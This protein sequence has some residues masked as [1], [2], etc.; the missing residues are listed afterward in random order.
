M[1]RSPKSISARP[2]SDLSTDLRRNG[3]ADSGPAGVALSLPRREAVHPT[4]ECEYPI[5]T[6]G[7][8][9]RFSRDSSWRSLLRR[10]R[11]KLAL[12]GVDLRVQPGEIFGLLGP[13]GAGK[14]TLMKVLAGLLLPTAGKAFVG[15]LDVVEQSLGARRQIG[16]VHGDER[17]FYWRLSVYEN[18]RFYARL[19]RIPKEDGER[20]IREL[21]DLVDLTSVA[22]VR[23]DRFSSGMKQRAAI[24]RGLLNDPQILLMDEPTRNLDPVAAQDVRRFINERVAADGRRTVLLATNLMAEAEAL[25]DRLALLNEGRIC[26]AGTIDDF[27]RA[28]Q[29]EEMHVIAVSGIEREKLLALSAIP[30]IRSLTVSASEDE[31]YKVCLGTARGS[32]AVPQAIRHIVAD[33]GYVWSSKP[34]ELSLEEV[35]HL[36][37]RGDGAR[38][39]GAGKGATS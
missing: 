12:D 6:R 9:K 13:N 16:L 32:S 5:E 10:G 1:K 36:A 11:D 7:L 14:T 33:G 17:T 25:C 23:M 38:I 19:C 22:H 31:T 3:E 26:L 29:V 2:E 15:G 37:I 27:R 21:L 24:A 34:R 8:V 28:V 18:L 30:A 20:R 39:A 35:F 4:S